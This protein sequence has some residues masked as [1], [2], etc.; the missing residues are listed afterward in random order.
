MIARR[1][2]GESRSIRAKHEQDAL[3]AER[4]RGWRSRGSLRGKRSSELVAMASDQPRDLNTLGVLVLTVL[5]TTACL[6]AMFL[7]RLWRKG[8]TKTWRWFA[9]TSADG[10]C[11]RC[12]CACMRRS[13]GRLVTGAPAA[14]FELGW[15]AVTSSNATLVW[16]HNRESFLADDSF[17]LEIKGADEDEWVSIYRGT[18]TSHREK[19]LTPGTSFAARVRTV[20][21][22]GQSAW[23][24]ETHFLTRQIPVKNG[25]YGPALEPAVAE[26]IGKET[27]RDTKNEAGCAYTW[28][29]T[30]DEVTIRLA[31]PRGCRGRDFEVEFRPTSLRVMHKPSHKTLLEGALYANVKHSEC[32]WDLEDEECVLIL[33]LEKSVKSDSS[34]SGQYA[35]PASL[36]LPLP[37][38]LC[39][40]LDVC[41]T[42]LFPVQVLCSSTRSGG[43]VW[44]RGI[45]RLT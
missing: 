29:Q 37:L 44:W 45:R 19:T 39:A 33:G 31:C 28:T 3:A 25:G 30:D 36:P 34:F 27:L 26:L 8:C 32:T 11:Y 17:E 1:C 4:A 16:K 18:N 9:R 24:E 42:Q 38:P 21:H 41:V 23:S 13:L 12:C 10:P 7:P 40:C 6:I 5:F 43:R 35:P 2:C 22:A 15:R 20:N 14:P